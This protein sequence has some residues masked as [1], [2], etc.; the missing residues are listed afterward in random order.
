MDA[1]IR[2]TRFGMSYDCEMVES[3]AK[4]NKSKSTKLALYAY[5]EDKNLAKALKDMQLGEAGDIII[6][7]SDRYFW[8]LEDAKILSISRE[9]L[10]RYIRVKIEVSYSKAIGTTSMQLIKRNAALKKILDDFDCE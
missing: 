4:L 6:C 5:Y 3:V 7:K 2:D 1:I 9:Y 8:M 10:E